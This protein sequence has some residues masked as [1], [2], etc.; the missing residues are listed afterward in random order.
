[1]PAPLAVTANA[2]NYIAAAKLNPVER[3]L[4]QGVMAR[5]HLNIS[6]ALRLGLLQLASE[7]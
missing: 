3:Q 6:Q 5:H 2:R 7:A 1:M 4:L